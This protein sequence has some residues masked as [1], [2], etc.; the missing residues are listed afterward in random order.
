MKAGLPTGKKDY[1]LVDVEVV[2]PDIDYFKGY[3]NY[4]FINEYERDGVS[5][6][7]KDAGGLKPTNG[8]AIMYGQGTSSMEY[9]VKN[10][11]VKF[12]TK[13]EA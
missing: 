5:I 6:P 4:S 13:K 12:K 9:P 2:Y 1:R 11:R 3:E 10:L 7:M 8:G